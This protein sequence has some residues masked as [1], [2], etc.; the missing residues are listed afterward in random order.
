MRVVDATPFCVSSH[1]FPSPDFDFILDSYS[2]GSLHRFISDQCGRRLKRVSSLIRAAMPD[3]PDR[4]LLNMPEGMAV[5]VVRSVNV[6]R[7]TGLPVEYV[8]TKFRG[9]TIQ[10]SVKP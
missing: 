1:Y 2:G 4:R 3:E 6:E 7:I 8:E 5:L 10:I 9:D